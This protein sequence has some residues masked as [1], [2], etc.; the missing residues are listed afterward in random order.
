MTRLPG[1]E[2]AA[3]VVVDMQNG[4]LREGGS[5]DRIGL[6]VTRLAA[7]IEPCVKLVAAARS[8]GVPV[9][10]T[11]YVYRADFRDGGLLVEEIMP[12]LR[13]C[14]ALVAGSDDA[15]LV[16]ELRPREG[17]YVLDKNRPSSFYATPLETWLNGLGVEELVVCG[18]TTNCCVET[19]VRDA[20]QRDYRTFVVED[21]VAEFDEERHAVALRSMGMLF[22]H[23]VRV[24]QVIAAW[25]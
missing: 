23:P 5:C 3:L 18:V 10:F 17:E 6:P 21:A 12:A 25:Q 24:D 4:F 20:S 7:A 19:T 13:E 2:R 22:A 1:K 15:E 9:I 16:D 8:A 11:R 14:N